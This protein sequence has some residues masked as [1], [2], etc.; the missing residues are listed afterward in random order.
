[1][2]HVNT[3]ALYLPLNLYVNIRFNIHF[4]I[5]RFLT[6]CSGDLGKLLGNN[7]TVNSLKLS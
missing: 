7:K 5:L 3:L 1:M 4:E 6:C 2:L